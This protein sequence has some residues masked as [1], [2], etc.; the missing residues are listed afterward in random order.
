M[1]NLYVNG[2]GVDVNY[3][4]AFEW[5]ENAVE[6]EDQ[7]AQYNMGVMYQNGRGVDVNYEKALEWYEKAGFADAQ[8]NLSIMYY[9]GDGVDLNHE[10]AYEW[11]YKVAK[12][13]FSLAQE[14]MADRHK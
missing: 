7:Y 4:K 3:K 8:Y 13:G 5:Y 1:G 12:Q 6:Q 14:I 9:D 2:D 11:Y 10:K